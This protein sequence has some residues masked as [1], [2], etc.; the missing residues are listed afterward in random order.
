MRGQIYEYIFAQS[1]GY[2]VSYPSN[3]LQRDWKIVYEQ[4]TLFYR[5]SFL[6]ECSLVRI[7]EQTNISLLL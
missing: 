3:I 7:Y 1:R 6:F 2:C 4:L 5:A